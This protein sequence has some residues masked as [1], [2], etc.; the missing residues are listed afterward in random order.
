MTKNHEYV[1]GFNRFLNSK[2][3]EGKEEEKNHKSV[4]ANFSWLL[5]ESPCKIM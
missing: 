5:D 3:L 1:K 4:S 2:G